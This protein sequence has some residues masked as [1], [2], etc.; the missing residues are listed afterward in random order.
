MHG[1][2]GVSGAVVESAVCG[3]V[4]TVLEEAGIIDLGIP[5]A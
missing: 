3:Y 1:G 5:I 4:A 2:C